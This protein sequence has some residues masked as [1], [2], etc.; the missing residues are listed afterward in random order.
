MVSLQVVPKKVSLVLLI[1]HPKTF[2]SW[3]CISM[4]CMVSLQVVLKKVSLV[5][6]IVHPKNLLQLDLYSNG[7]YGFY[8]SPTG[9]GFSG[10]TIILN[11]FLQCSLLVSLPGLLKTRIKKG[12]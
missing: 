4:E 2:Y 11:Q 10:R 5:L 7:I 3:T 1:V 8:T 9:K 12:H 6:L